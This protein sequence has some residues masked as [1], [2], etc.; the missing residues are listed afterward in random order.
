MAVLAL[1]CCLF[2]GE[3]FLYAN[4]WGLQVTKFP[5]K[6]IRTSSFLSSTAATTISAANNNNNNLN[7]LPMG[8]AD[9]CFRRGAELE[10]IG[11]VLYTSTLF[12]SYTQRRMLSPIY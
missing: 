5:N 9:I 1:S 10:K 11:Q 12:Y 4:G 3:C 2:A 6:R 8:E 7:L